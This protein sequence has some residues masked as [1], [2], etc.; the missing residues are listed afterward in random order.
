MENQFLNTILLDRCTLK[1]KKYSTQKNNQIFLA[2][3]L[4]EQL[5]KACQTANKRSIL[6]CLRCYPDQ[7]MT[8]RKTNKFSA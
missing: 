3:N 6:S 4:I 8:L 5:K 2:Y 7:D 1:Q